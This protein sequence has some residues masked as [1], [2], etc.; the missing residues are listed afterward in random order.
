[1]TWIRLHCYW[2]RHVQQHKHTQV[3]PCVSLQSHRDATM[4]PIDTQVMIR[5]CHYFNKESYGSS[6]ENSQPRV[7]A[8]SI[9]WPKAATSLN[10]L[11]PF[12]VLSSAYQCYRSTWSYRLCPGCSFRPSVHFTNIHRTIYWE[13]SNIGTP[14]WHWKGIEDALQGHERHGSCIVSPQSRARNVA[15]WNSRG[16]CSRP[17]SV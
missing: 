2:Y 16:C 10:S 12:P 6:H 9:H 14:K 15:I 5:T 11:I 17:A 8:T 4:I 1:M 7:A 3:Q 13:S